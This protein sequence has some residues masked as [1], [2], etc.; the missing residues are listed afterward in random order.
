MCPQGACHEP[1]KGSIMLRHVWCQ[2]LT[3]GCESG[4]SVAVACVAAGQGKSSWS[5][6]LTAVLLMALCGGTAF[7]LAPPTTLPPPAASW[8]LA[9]SGVHLCSNEMFSCC[10]ATSSLLVALI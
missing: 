10:P 5:R 7:M 8:Q 4:L 9:L 1:A 2:K 3:H 6:W